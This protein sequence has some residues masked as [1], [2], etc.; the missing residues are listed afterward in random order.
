MG[1]QIEPGAKDPEMEELELDDAS[2][3][4]T[5]LID[6][7]AEELGAEELLA[8]PDAAAVANPSYAEETVVPSSA[9]A[10]PVRTYLKEMGSVYLLSKEEEVGLARR[11][12]EGKAA[13]ARELLPTRALVDEIGRLREKLS[14][15]AAAEDDPEFD[16]D[17]E[18]FLD[19]DGQDIRGVLEKI[20]EALGIHAKAARQKEG[21]KARDRFYELV[22]EI[23]KTADIY[24][25][26]IE[27][28]RAAAVET[29]KLSE[30]RALLEKNLGV[31]AAA[32]SPEYAA[33]EK[34]TEELSDRVGMDSEGLFALLARIDE[35]AF[36]R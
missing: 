16:E 12:E 18:V 29:E 35:L 9:G 32:L 4:G 1:R 15:Y 11:I 22:L 20:D 14:G 36:E 17:E 30:R 28:L 23:E 8:P 25:K 5:D 24:D 2:E 10:D 21:A 33:I 6:E 31:K 34:E 19:A 13:I 7:G 3:E 27:S 26:A